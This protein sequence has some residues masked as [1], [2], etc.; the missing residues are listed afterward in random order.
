LDT[1]TTAGATTCRITRVKTR[2]FFIFSIISS[3]P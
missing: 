3:L 1:A 2:N